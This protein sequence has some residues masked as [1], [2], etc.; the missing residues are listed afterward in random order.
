M[1]PVLINLDLVLIGF[2][3]ICDNEELDI[4]YHAD[5]V[6]VKLTGGDELHFKIKRCFESHNHKKIINAATTNI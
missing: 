5:I 6:L 2:R 4:I 1:I 3:N